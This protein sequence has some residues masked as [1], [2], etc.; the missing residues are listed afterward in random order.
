MEQNE[1]SSEE[2]RGTE[3]QTNYNEDQAFTEEK[4]I[5]DEKRETA[6]A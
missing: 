5:S 3:V 2:L 4:K 1:A 6:R